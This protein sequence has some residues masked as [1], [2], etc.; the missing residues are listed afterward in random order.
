MP[1]FYKLKE[2]DDIAILVV[3]HSFEYLVKDSRTTRPVDNS[4]RGQLGP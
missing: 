1:K 4:A 2:I 3:M